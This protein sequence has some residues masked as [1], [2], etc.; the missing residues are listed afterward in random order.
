MSSKSGMFDYA[1]AAALLGVTVRTA[2]RLR[3][4]K[5]LRAVRIGHRTIRFRPVDIER[6]KARL[7]GEEVAEW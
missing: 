3:A 4:E 6:A 1:E 7:A 2:R 5:V